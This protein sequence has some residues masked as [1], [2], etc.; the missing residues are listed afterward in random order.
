LL[1]NAGISKVYYGD[2]YRE[3]RSIEVAEQL[4]IELVD[5]SGLG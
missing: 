3:K 1:A 2:F 4:K 5:L